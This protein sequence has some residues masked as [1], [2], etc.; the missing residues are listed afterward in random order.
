MQIHSVNSE[1]LRRLL[2]LME[3]SHWLN[4]NRNQNQHNKGS[5]NA[6]SECESPST[7]TN[8]LEEDSITGSDANEK[9]TGN[10]ESS[11]DQMAP[12]STTNDSSIGTI[13]EKHVYKY[14]CAQCSLAFKTAEKLAL[15]SQYH[16][17]RDS[18]KCRMCSRSFRSIQALL[19][20][21]E[22]SHNEVPAE[23]LAHYKLGLMNHPLLLAGLSGQV[24]DPSTNELL[25]KE[26]NKDDVEAMDTGAAPGEDN[27]NDNVGPDGGPPA[28]K[29]LLSSFFGRKSGDKGLNYPLEKYLDPNRPYKC[30]VCKESFTQK[31]ILLVHYNSVSHLHR[32][33]KTM[34]DQ[35]AKEQAG[36][37]GSGSEKSPPRVTSLE[38]ALSNLASA[39]QIRGDEDSADKPYKCNIC[40]VGYNQGSTLDIH[41]RSVLHQNRASKLQELAITGQI[42]L[43]KPLIEQPDSKVL[44]DQHKKLLQ[45]M[46]SPKSSLNSSNNTS[47][48]SN[49]G[50]SPPNNVSSP[51]VGGSPILNFQQAL[52]NASK[53]QQSPMAKSLTDLIANAHQQGD[54]SPLASQQQLLQLFQNMTNNTGDSSDP[55]SSPKP[56]DDQQNQGKKSSSQAVKNMLENYGFELVMQFNENRQKRKRDEEEQRKKELDALLAANSNGN[57]NGSN[58]EPANT[59]ESKNETSEVTVEE[60]NE[61]SETTENKETNK[62]DDEEKNDDEKSSDKKSPP[63]IVKSKCPACS[64]EFSSIWVLKA[65][66][67]E[68]HKD[69]VPQEFL[70]KYIE[71]LKSNMDKSGSSEE[72][73]QQ[74]QTESPIKSHPNK[75]PPSTFLTPDKSSDGE[76]RSNNFPETSTPKSRSSTPAVDSS[77]SNQPRPSSTSRKDAATPTGSINLADFQGNFQKAMLNA[78]QQ[79]QGIN[80]MLLQM[81]Q[82]QGMNPLVAM[83]LHP[84]LIPPSML[85]SPNANTGPSPPMM[86][87][88]SGPMSAPSPNEGSSSGPDAAQLQLLA[89][90]GIDPKI[91]AQSGLDPKILI[92]MAQLGGPKLPD[93]AMLAMLAGGASPTSDKNGPPPGPDPKLI[94]QMMQMGANAPQGPDPKLLLQLA[95]MGGGGDPKLPGFPGLDKAGLP[96]PGLPNFGGGPPLPDPKNLIM[97]G[98]QKPVFQQPEQTKRAR[99]RITDEQLKVLRSNF[100]INNS[101]T[102]TQ[103]QTMAAQTGLPHKV[104]K[105]WFRNTLFKE[106]QRNK[107]S[108]Y[109]FSN[110]PTTMLNLEEYEKTGEPKVI[111]LKPEEQKEY[112][113][114]PVSNEPGP[115]PSPSKSGPTENQDEQEKDDVAGG[116]NELRVKNNDELMTSKD[117]EQDSQRSTP[118]LSNISSSSSTLPTSNA[119]GINSSIAPSLTLSSILSSQMG[120]PAKPGFPGLPLPHPLVPNFPNANTPIPGGLPEFLNPLANM[121]ANEQPQGQRS[122]TPQSQCPGGGP[123]GKRANRTRFTDYQI[124]VLQEFF[125]NNAYPKDDDLEY[126]SKLLSLSPRVIVVWFQNARQKARKIY[127]NQPPLDPNDDGAGRFTRTPGLNYQCKKCLLVFQ[128]YYELIRHQKQHCFKEEDAKRSAQAQKAAAQ[129][130][131]QFSSQQHGPSNSSGGGG[132][133]G[134]GGAQH[135]DDSNSSTNQDR[136]IPSPMFNPG[137]FDKRRSLDGSEEWPSPPQPDQLPS[138]FP[139]LPPLGAPGGIGSDEPKKMTPSM[140]D[141][142]ASKA[143][144]PLGGPT[145]PLGDSLGGFPKMTAPSTL[146]PSYPPSSPFGILQQQAL[147]ISRE[148][149]S[150]DFDNESVGSSPSS[151]KRKHSDDGGDLE[152]KDDSGQPRDKRLRT[153]ILPEQLDYLY[154]K[155]QM[156]SNPSRKMLEQIASEVGLRKRVV[157]VWFQNTRA[158]ERKGQFRA[159]QQVINKRCPFCPAIFRVRSALESHLATKHADHYTRGE[160]DIDALPDAEGGGFMDGD[161]GRSTSTP[162]SLTGSMPPLIPTTSSQLQSMQ[163]YY[164]DTMKRYMNDLQQNTQNKEGDGSTSNND[165]EPGANQSTGSS[166]KQKALDLTS[167]QGAPALDLSKEND[168]DSFWDG[169]SSCNDMQ[170]VGSPLENNKGEQG[171][172]RI[173]DFEVDEN[174]SLQ[175]ETGGAGGSPSSP[176]IGNEANKSSP[177]VAG[178]GGDLSSAGSNKRFR[179]QMSSVQ[180]K[181]MKAVFQFYKTP[182]MTECSNLGHQVG[183]QKR[184]VQ[185]WFQNARAKEKKARLSLQQATG[186]E[187]EAP[188]PPVECSVCNH[189]YQNNLTI[190]DHLFSHEHL[191][192]VRQAIESG[193]FEPESPGEVL[194]QALAALQPPPSTSP[195]AKDL[196]SGSGGPPTM[197]PG[198]PGD[199][200][201]QQMLQ[202]AAQGLKLPPLPPLPTSSGDSTTTPPGESS[203]STPGG[204]E[205]QNAPPPKDMEKALMQLYGMGHGITSFPSGV[206]QA[207]PFLHPAMFSATGRC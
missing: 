158:R 54:T 160:I 126:L 110:A 6:N 152:D 135:S 173:Y 59:D 187:P 64:K 141:Q 72:D 121:M 46:L 120:I 49:P 80:P 77:S 104:I 20:H 73:Q 69:V 171:N 125:E 29:S 195:G 27:D 186:K 21:V 95:Q 84:P 68:V 166:G 8:P 142:L 2:V 35:Q 197:V 57:G 93:P 98:N 55:S 56:S 58:A 148:M 71:E 124:K 114:G 63:E 41:I 206:A 82:L 14:R 88:P 150:D 116:S 134:F 174:S 143:P 192:K 40:K 183:L 38:S 111:P 101:P 107:D 67:E 122:P 43:S 177:G 137:L 3:G 97:G 7:T 207:N 139:P 146:F 24:L 10:R 129:A 28:K 61:A 128:R 13:S 65:H 163:K 156:E 81:A 108:P 164:E 175:D 162:S 144:P 47:G 31:N 19:K 37:A 159:H 181:M 182:T 105:H 89:K 184:V 157:Q 196:P 79:S 172:S 132:G 34:Q 178:G 70:E 12:T 44:Q 119:S 87:S 78:Q 115:A 188:P 100:D 23:E 102:E 200:N 167:G 4:N 113:S 179:T 169:K 75:P 30:D 133:G 94:L 32:L 51:P 45:D 92:Q 86:K 127:E 11:D 145:P 16:V 168:N 185:V 201:V 204:G 18:T 99:T 1:G 112:T 176:S 9:A 5:S 52:L 154:Q 50:M 165:Q 60:K 109:N 198:G 191:E 90:L 190:Q 53:Q 85:P 36:S 42:D 136:P 193:Q 118:L 149:D 91:L 170:S 106:R 202:M 103:I 147:N 194:N 76:E 33:K 17:I 151:S 74:Q 48:S 66:S 131:A 199:K 205:N 26:S 153:T 25:R 117:Q 96:F 130:A 22:T 39:K 189:T 15:H 62:R 140:F 180:I 138:P 161:P 83:N 123:Q 203:S 155:Y